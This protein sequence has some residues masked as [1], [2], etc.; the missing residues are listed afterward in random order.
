MPESLTEI[1][2]EAFADA[3]FRF[4]KLPD[5]TASV[6]PRAFSRCT[7]LRYIVIPDYLKQIDFS[8][9]EGTEDVIV[10]RFSQ[11]GRVYRLH[12]YM[13]MMAP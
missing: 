10:L 12:D 2:E 9:F 8:A 1:E 13:N 4:V 3:A 5:S 6:G 11:F 7:E